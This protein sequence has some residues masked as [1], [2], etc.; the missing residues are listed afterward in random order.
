MTDEA[1]TIVVRAALTLAAV[2][3]VGCVL[4]LSVIGLEAVVKAIARHELDDYD[5]EKDGQDK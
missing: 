2:S 3:F 5:D 1:I 4:A